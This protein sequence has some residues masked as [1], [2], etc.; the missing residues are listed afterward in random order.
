MDEG[1]RL[2]M[3]GPRDGI[4]TRWIALT[5]MIELGNLEQF[6]DPIEVMTLGGLGGLGGGGIETGLEVD[7]RLAI[8]PGLG[9]VGRL[10]D[11]ERDSHDGAGRRS[12]S[13]SSVKKKKDGE[14]GDATEGW[15]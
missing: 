13:K 7:Q 3:R 4:P 2:K 9:Q 14:M 15:G 12:R 5:L 6:D 1:G 11:W 8:R 10:M